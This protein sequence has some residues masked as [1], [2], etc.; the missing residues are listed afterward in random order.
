MNEFSIEHD[1]RFSLS[2]T[3]SERYHGHHRQVSNKEPRYLAAKRPFWGN[4]P[5]GGEQ[6]ERAVF[7]GYYCVTCTVPTGYYCVKCTVPTGYYCIT[8]TVPAGYYCITCTVPTG[9]H[10]VTCTVP[11]IPSLYLT[12]FVSHMNNPNRIFEMN[13]K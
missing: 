13:C 11:T 4:A 3:C 1:G 2:L 7:T 6:G 5:S 8:C 10:C 9:Y 12:P